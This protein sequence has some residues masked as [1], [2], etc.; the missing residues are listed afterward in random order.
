M[1]L[2]FILQ[3]LN[4]RLSIVNAK[5]KRIKD[6]TV[7]SEADLTVLNVLSD[8]HKFIETLLYTATEHKVVYCK[9]CGHKNVVRNGVHLFEC[10]RCDHLNDG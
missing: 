6:Y 4:T 2:T 5:A 7:K 9:E 10:D 1:E 3:L 8:E